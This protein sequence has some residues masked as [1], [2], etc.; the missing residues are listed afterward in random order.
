[1]TTVVPFRP[2]MVGQAGSI[3]Q[4]IGV[5]QLLGEPG[6]VFRRDDVGMVRQRRQ[7]RLRL[8][9]IPVDERA[10]VERCLASQVEGRRVDLRQCPECGVLV[11]RF[12]RRERQRI[13]RQLPDQPI[14]HRLW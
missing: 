6:E 10:V 8:R 14:E 9:Q 2:S 3:A 1:M 12:H 5:G 7:C 11:G 13:E 4:P